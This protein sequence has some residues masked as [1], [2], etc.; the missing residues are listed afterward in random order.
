M[1]YLLRKKSV[2]TL[3]GLTLSAT[4]LLPMANA[5]Q[6]PHP[7]VANASSQEIIQ[8][9][10]FGVGSVAEPAKVEVQLPEDLS[11]DKYNQQI[12]EFLAELRAEDP[13]RFDSVAA[14]LTSG[15]APKVEEALNNGGKWF[16]TA[17]GSQAQ[18][19]TDVRPRCGAVWVCV[20]AAAAIS[21]VG[22]QNAVAAT[23]VAGL[24]QAVVAWNGMYLPSS[25]S[26]GNASTVERDR[27]IRIITENLAR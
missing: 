21:W 20:A 14:G 5:A 22:V 8:G 13:D 15:S 2:V 27:A 24:T 11:R 3:L 18:Q 4:L 17:A 10:F 1:K 23:S 26:A 9:V 25:T 19:N 6:A 7:S 12:N 16:S